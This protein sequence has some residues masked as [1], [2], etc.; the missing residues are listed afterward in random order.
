MKLDLY[1]KAIL[2]V[3]AGALMLIAIQPMLTPLK[4]SAKAPDALDDI[5]RSIKD[6][7]Y[8]I[9]DIQRYGLRQRK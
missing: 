1:T 5:A 4:A 2:T 8:A 3:I 6:I 9:E 7:E